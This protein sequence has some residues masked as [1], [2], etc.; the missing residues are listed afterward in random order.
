AASMA[1]SANVAAL[2]EGVMKAM[3][4][5]KL[6]LTALFVA[7]LCVI[8][9][10]WGGLSYRA[11]AKAEPI[12]QGGQQQ[13]A[14]TGDRKP[15][16]ARKPQD[17]GPT[18]HVIVGAQTK[19]LLEILQKG[20]LEYQAAKDKVGERPSKEAMDLYKEAFMK[21]FVLSSEIANA[22]SKK[23]TAAKAT[24]EEN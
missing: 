17:P 5:K 21:G 15:S 1:V 19:Y 14:Q 11:A 7:A 9:T 2:T 4:L 22:M 18:E 10:G 16:H 8:G 23:A 20:L 6:K 12:A 24:S 3:L 13:V